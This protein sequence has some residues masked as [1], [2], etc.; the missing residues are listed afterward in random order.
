M[1]KKMFVKYLVS[2]GVAFGVD[3]FAFAF[4][5]F[6]ALPLMVANPLARLMGALTAFTLNRQWTFKRVSP[7]T[8]R[9][10]F[11][12]YALLWC[13]STLCS[14]SALAALIHAFPKGDDVL[15]KVLV[16]CVIVVM[17]FVVS[18]V[19]VFRPGKDCGEIPP[20]DFSGHK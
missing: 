18:R 3:I 16:E 5:R 8:W 2:G 15:F 1:M 4:F 17:N 11:A 14:T 9:R 10:E 12:R 19:W 20:K 13:F 6:L 7:G